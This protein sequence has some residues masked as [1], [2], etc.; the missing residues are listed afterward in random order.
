MARTRATDLDPDDPLDQLQ[1][2]AI[3]R[4][5]GALTAAEFEERKAIVLIRRR[6]GGSP[7]T[8]GDASQPSARP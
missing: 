1:K 5:Q 3:L 6:R 8:T 7:P 2:L 4:D